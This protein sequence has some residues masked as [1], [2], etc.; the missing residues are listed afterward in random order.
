LLLPILV[1]VLLSAKMNAWFYVAWM[2]VSF[3]FVVPGALTTVLHAM[4]SAQQSTLA[5]KARVTMGIAFLISLLAN[6]V[7]QVGTKQALSVFGSS[8]ADGA[9]W[10]LRILLL[11]AFP[12]IIKNHYISICRIYDR[13]IPAM[14]NMIPGG[15]LELGVAV[16]GAHLGGLVGLSVG[17]VAAIYIE[18]VFMIPTVYKAVWSIGTP[19]LP[20][21]TEDGYLDIGAIHLAETLILPVI[22]ES[23]IGREAFGFVETGPLPA[24]GHARRQVDTRGQCQQSVKV[25]HYK[26]SGLR[27]K[28]PQLER[29]IDHQITLD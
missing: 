27:L 17:W 1:T 24:I 20:T 21:E 23:Y 6:C 13:I 7:L 2:I 15:L 5:R 9:S 8:Y 11:A 28:P 19:T 18:S 4:N 14:I 12:L 22:G 3:V 16:L 29:Y 26:R 25:N 10:S